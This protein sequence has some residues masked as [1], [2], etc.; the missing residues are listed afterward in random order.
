[1]K[2]GFRQCMAWLHTWTGLLLGWLLFAV[3]ATGTA[4]YFQDEITR[5]MRPEVTGHP[6]TSQSAEG[7]V[8]WLGEQAADARSWYITL[9][10][11]RGAETTVFW[12]PGEKAAGLGR[13]RQDTQA[14]L[15]GDGN[16]VA[17][18]ETRGGFFLYRFHFDLHYMPVYWARYLVGIAAMFMLVAILSGIVTHKKIFVDFFLLRFGKGQRSWLDAHNITAVTALP[19]HLMITYTGLVTLA[20]MYMPWGIAANYAQPT[21]YYQQLRGE[22]PPVEPSGVA[23]PMAPVAPMVADAERRWNGAKV[24]VV[25]VANPGDT[26]ATVTLIRAME[27]AIGTRGP[28]VTFSGATGKPIAV[29]PPQ[30]G[31]AATESVMIGLHAGRFA[32]IA[33]RWF[34]FLSGVG[35]TIM[36]ASGLVLWT[37][38]RRAKLPNPARPHFGFRVVERL[39]LAAIGGLMAGMAAYFLANRLLPLEMAGR[40]EWEIHCMFIVWGASLVWAIARPVRQAWIEVL[41]VGAALYAAIPVVN[42]LTTSRNPIA[43]LAAGDWLFPAFDLVMLATAATLGWSARKVRRHV[44]KLPAQSAPRARELALA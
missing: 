7:A 34:Y 41:T 2:E 32:D 44:S 36:I 39:N 13:S 6:S 10:T 30:G 24:G 17:A 9:P 20:V 3:F 8:R 38:K 29:S 18:R 37:V 35:G 15:D 4:A 21:G 27:S 5:W 42:A 23:T 19:F 12:V 25:T 1:V 43:S 11:S 40:A 16:K 31:A 33:L 22:L 28:S 14:V 26:T